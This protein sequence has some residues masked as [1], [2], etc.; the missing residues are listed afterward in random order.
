[1]CFL[2]WSCISYFSGMELLRS[3]P[4]G[5]EPREFDEVFSGLEAVLVIFVKV[6][7]LKT[8]LLLRGSC[9]TLTRRSRFGAV[10]IF[11][12]EEDF[13]LPRHYLHEGDL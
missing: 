3:S 4:V 12:P 13:F 10:L 6:D 2:V 11:L 1:M 7:L 5:G 8:P 9:G